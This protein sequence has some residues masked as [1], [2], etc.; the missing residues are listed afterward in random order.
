MLDWKS[1]VS[2]DIGSSLIKMA[3][4]SRSSGKVRLERVGIIENP[5]P[6]FRTN[7]DTAEGS[8]IA[9]II[10][11]GLRMS[12][13]RAKDVVSSLSGPSII[14]QY[15]KLPLLSGKELENAVYLEAQRVMSMKIGE[16]E[17]GFQVLPSQQ[18]QRGT[19]EV[20]FAAAPKT[21]IHQRMN[22]LKRAGLNPITIDIDCLALA[23]CFLKLNP[24]VSDQGVLVLNLGAELINLAILSHNSLE[25]IRDI[26]L[27][28][29]APLNFT[30]ENIAS[31]MIEEIRR[32]INY[33]EARS[34]GRKV[35]RIF[36]TGGK[37]VASNIDKLLSD[38]L[39]LPVERWNPLK[40]LEFNSGKRGARLEENQ[41]YLLAITVGL[42][43]REKEE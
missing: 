10:K 33:Y 1:V 16:M 2:I 37:T 25:F 27:G 5:I 40:S 23:N 43:L 19:Q 6:S 12:S 18:S 35:T 42:G 29:K 15:F 14:V 31:K 7:I 4:L 3:Q 8:S 32:S 11:R 30:R 28:L 38:N 39:E 34:G 13:I 24:P 20:I 36:L 17:I 26:S 21:M 22:T 9:R 41:G